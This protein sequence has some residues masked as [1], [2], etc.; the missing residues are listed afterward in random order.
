M[1]K[2]LRFQEGEVPK[3]LL[4][5]LEYQEHHPELIIQIAMWHIFTGL[6]PH[7]AHFVF[8]RHWSPYS[9]AKFDFVTTWN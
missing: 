3:L 6:P 8:I 5:N 1:K 9:R 4:K 2:F 7:I